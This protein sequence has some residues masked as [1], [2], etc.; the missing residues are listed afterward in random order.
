MVLIDKSTNGTYVVIDGLP[1][2]F[3]KRGECILRGKG[4]ILFASSS[5]D[6]DS[7]C[8]EFELI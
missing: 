8:A 1:E 6:P 4:P 5:S 3:V 2:H 7:D